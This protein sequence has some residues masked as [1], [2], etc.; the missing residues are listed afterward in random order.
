MLVNDEYF[1]KE[2]CLVFMFFSL[3]YFDINFVFIVINWLK[4]VD[5]FNCFIVIIDG[6][7]V[8]FYLLVG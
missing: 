4:C 8:I 5:F 6:V 1:L 3:E 7:K 2:I